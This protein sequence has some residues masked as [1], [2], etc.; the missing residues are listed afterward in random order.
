MCII[1]TLFNYTFSDPALVTMLLTYE[2]T[3]GTSGCT[4]T[5]IGMIPGIPLID[6]ID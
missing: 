4:H 5:A 3:S 1:S 2:P 6:L